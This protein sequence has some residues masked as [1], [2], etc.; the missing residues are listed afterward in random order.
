MA[1]FREL[2][3]FSQLG[4]YFL[5]GLAVVALGEYVDAPPFLPLVSAKA[6]LEEKKTTA[7]TRKTEVNTLLHFEQDLPRLDTQI[8]AIQRELETQRRLVPEEKKTDEFIRLLQ[9]EATHARIALRRLTARPVVSQ[10]YYT[11]MPFEL[12]LDGSYYDTLEFFKQ[13]GG[14]TRIITAT[15]LHLQGIGASRGQRTYPP[16]TTVSGTVTVITYFLPKTGPSEAGSAS[17]AQ[18]PSGR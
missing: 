15:E 16:D 8:Q 3:W 6:T 4:L 9:D 7:Q 5:V 2:P 11:E 14:K 10:Q 13:L 18:T 12:E 1:G 17:G